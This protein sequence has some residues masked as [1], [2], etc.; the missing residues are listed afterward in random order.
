MYNIKLSMNFLVFVLAALLGVCGL[1]WLEDKAKE[2]G[3]PI[4]QFIMGMGICG[5]CFLAL[6]IAII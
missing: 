2:S 3:K 6:I 5:I 1:I 4:P